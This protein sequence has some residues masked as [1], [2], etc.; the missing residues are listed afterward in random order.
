VTQ[1]TRRNNNNP[2]QYR[3]RPTMNERHARMAESDEGRESRW[4]MMFSSSQDN[5]GVSAGG[6]SNPIGGATAEQWQMSAFALV[7]MIVFLSALF[8]HL[9][10]ESASSST[11]S[12]SG[13]S[14]HHYNLHHGGSGS[15]SKNRRMQRIKRKTSSGTRKKKTDEWSSDEEGGE[16]DRVDGTSIHRVDSDCQGPSTTPTN[17]AGTPTADSV[18]RTTLYYPYQ[19]RHRK[20]SVSGYKDTVGAAYSPSAAAAASSAAN[21]FHSRSYFLNPMDGPVMLPSFQ[22]PASSAKIRLS[23]YQN[24]PT[25]RQQIQQQP[26]D[27]SQNVNTSNAI[28]PATPSVAQAG[29]I[30]DAEFLATGLASFSD[31]NSNNNHD[32]VRSST[33]HASC[34]QIQPIHL[35]SPNIIVDEDEDSPAATSPAMSPGGIFNRQPSYTQNDITYAPYGQMSHFNELDSVAAPAGAVRNENH[36]QV[37]QSGS[38]SSCNNNSTSFDEASNQGVILVNGTQHHSKAYGMSSCQIREQRNSVSSSHSGVLSPRV[39]IDFMELEE[40]PRAGLTRRTVDVMGGGAPQRGP[41]VGTPNYNARQAYQAFSAAQ[42]RQQQQVV[43]QRAHS[44]DSNTSSASDDPFYALRLPQSS[45]MGGVAHSSP[46]AW[47]NVPSPTQQNQQQQQGGSNFPYIPKLDM[48]AAAAGETSSE[49]I[50]STGTRSIAPP[51]SMSIEE[52]RLVQMESGSAPHWQVRESASPNDAVDHSDHSESSSCNLLSP[53]SSWDQASLDDNPEAANEARN[54]I[55]HKRKKMTEATDAA[56]SLQSSIK[57]QELKLEEVIGGGGFGQVWKAVWRG[58]PV[59]VKVLTGSAQ[60]KHV[61]KAILE[62]FAAEINLLSGMRHPNIC[63]YMGA[64]VVPPNRSIITEL[65]ANGSLWDAL[66]LPL[67]APYCASDGLSRDT[68][69]AELYYPGKHGTPPSSTGIT[70]PPL[71]PAGS[72]PWILV[73]HVACGAARGMAYLHS[74]NPPI[75]HRKST[76]GKHV[77]SC[78]GLFCCCLALISFSFPAL[79]CLGDLKSANILL[80]ESYTAKVCDFGLSRIK[81]VERSMTGNCGTVQWMAP[82]VLAQTNVSCC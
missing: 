6:F 12:G 55:I 56:A 45:T 19:P 4:Q 29:N 35:T 8:L 66:R 28:N 69:P 79:S 67:N 52:L 31:A 71:P 3:L 15:A 75:L 7:G 11:G 2:N 39:E 81:S 51:R 34:Q 76:L 77:L 9:V 37:L 49:Q 17:A 1:H 44:K 13:S 24:T 82:E 53:A 61:S 57:F 38:G 60:A 64:C 59:A 42:K 27:A 18:A 22:S 43:L 50:S 16:T 78:L 48:S 54:S 26:V 14:S 72:W 30:N 23:A 41:I 20:P 21:G 47:S 33:S 80:N 73:K 63:L 40:T 65:A 74:G 58:T 32:H 36:F 46:A 25:R 10:S 5:G 68:W 62:E 70:P